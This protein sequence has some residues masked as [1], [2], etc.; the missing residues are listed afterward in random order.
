MYLF[1]TDILSNLVRPQPFDSLVERWRR[2]ATEFLFTSA[3][4][5]GELLYGAERSP[6]P[7]RD[8]L[9]TDLNRHV[10]PYVT[11]LPFDEAAART[12][13]SVR[14]GLE[15]QGIPLAIPDLLIAAV[16]LSRDLTLVTR[17]VAHFARVPGLRVENWVE[18]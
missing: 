7:R 17:N 3:I 13:A 9:L 4:N 5:I 8:V 15:R 6:A 11:V 14:A 1:D 10:F 2:T 16:A 12:Y 18:A